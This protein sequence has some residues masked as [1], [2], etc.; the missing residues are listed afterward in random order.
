MEEL[1]NALVEVILVGRKP[2]VRPV[3]DSRFVWFPRALRIPGA[4]Y[5]VEWLRTR[6]LGAK[7]W[8]ASGSIRLVIEP[9][10]VHQFPG[11]A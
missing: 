10:A 9:I 4:F 5:R 8:T 7:S 3:G 6:H 11:A 2:R 1:H